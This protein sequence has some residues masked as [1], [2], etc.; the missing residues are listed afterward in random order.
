MTIAVD[1]DIKQQNKQTRQ[2]SNAVFISYTMLYMATTI[3]TDFVVYYAIFSLVI[4][5]CLCAVG[6]L[7][8]C[9][10]IAASV[11]VVLLFLVFMTTE[12]RVMVWRL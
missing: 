10:R 8:R 6:C 3:Q 11:F 2:S 9:A 7:T 12:S 5:L 1:W 4:I